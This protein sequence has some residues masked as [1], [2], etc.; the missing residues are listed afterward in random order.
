[1]AQPPWKDALA[2]ARR[3]DAGPTPQD[4]APPLHPAP[5]AL[6]AVVA[7]APGLQG[8]LAERQALETRMQA[9]TGQGAA[10]P[11][12]AVEPLDRRRAALAAWSQSRD[13]ERESRRAPAAAFSPQAPPLRATAADVLRGTSA[14]TLR[15]TPGELLADARPSRLFES[16]ER[17]NPRA[18][19]D[20]PPLRPPGRPLGRREAAAPAERDRADPLDRRLARARDMSARVR[21][22]MDV[23]GRALERARDAVPGGWRGRARARIP[24]LGK[25]DHYVRETARKLQVAVGTVDEIGQ[26]ADRLRSLARDMREL[27]DAD[28][29]NDEARRERALDRL[30]TKRQEA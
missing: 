5:L 19:N 28:E 3:G 14:D 7:A 13:A 25:V 24:G 26:K 16:F 17:A 2:R 10:D 8:L 15:A 30:K 21:R 4:A 12:Y 18:A 22:G 1:M 23:A 20:D 11:R 9:I 6:D 27:K 29:A